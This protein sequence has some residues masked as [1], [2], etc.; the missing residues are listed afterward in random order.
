MA[1]AAD[2][3]GTTISTKVTSSKADGS[4]YTFL[5]STNFCQPDADVTIISSDGIRFQ[6]HKKNLALNTGGFPPLEL[7]STTE[8]REQVTFSEKGQI[9]DL[10]FHFVYPQHYPDLET[11][12]MSVLSELAEAAEKYEV[13]GAV[14]ETPNHPLEVFSY[15]TPFNYL[16]LADMAAPLVLG[17]PLPTIASRV[18]ANALVAWVRYITSLDTIR[19]NWTTSI[20]NSVATHSMYDQY[21][22]HT[23]GS[24][25]TGICPSRALL[26]ELTKSM[27]SQIELLRLAAV[28]GVGCVNCKARYADGL[29]RDAPTQYSQFAKFRTFLHEGTSP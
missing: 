10:L 28:A 26:T 5:Q 13:F 15:A 17:T 25:C 1:T 24:Q 6:L 23:A 11:I 19:L 27:L 14:F 7:T 9:L 29:I 21:G 18:P 8:L 22:R 3:K 16:D 2:K 4:P 12:E 20:L